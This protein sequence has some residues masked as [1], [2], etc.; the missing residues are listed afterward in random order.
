MFKMNCS[1]VKISFL[2]L[3][4]ASQTQEL[5]PEGDQVASLQKIASKFNFASNK[6]MDFLKLV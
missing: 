3:R 6:S 1:V 2:K 4:F 5:P